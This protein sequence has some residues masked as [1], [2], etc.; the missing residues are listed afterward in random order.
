MNWQ[1]CEGLRIVQTLIDNEQEEYQTSSG[2]FEVLSEKFKPQHHETMLSLQYCKLI[3]EKK[4]Q[5]INRIKDN[6]MI[7]EIIKELAKIKK[8]NEIT[9][10]QVLCR[11]KRVEAEMCKR[12]YC[13]QLKKPENG[14]DKKAKQS[15][16][17]TVSP[18][19]SKQVHTKMQIL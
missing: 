13:T 12:Q 18:R 19:N 17:E 1:D 14:Y 4:E 10:D 5:F 7:T 6:E 16:D 11:A 8:Y 15:C 9:S 3:R 2:L